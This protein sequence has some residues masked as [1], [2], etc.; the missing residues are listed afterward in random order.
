MMARPTA[1]PSSL[2]G[3][4]QAGGRPRV[5]GL[6]AQQ[7]QRGDRHEACRPC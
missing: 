4:Q 1:P 2:H 5:L 7:R 3:L 6:D